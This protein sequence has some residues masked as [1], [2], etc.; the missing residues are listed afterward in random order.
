MD[1]NT[2]SQW[3]NNTQPISKPYDRLIRL[4]YSNMKDIPSHLIQK[5]ECGNFQLIR[6]L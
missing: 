5:T 4:I 3:E 6:R 2:V 1:N